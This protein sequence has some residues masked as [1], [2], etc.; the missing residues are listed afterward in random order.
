MVFSVNA[1]AEAANNFQAFL[2]NAEKQNGTASNAG[3]NAEKSA[4]GRVWSSGAG[5]VYLA[6]ATFGVV[7]CL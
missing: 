6:L 4:T 2:A 5:A 3:S 1:K 7:L